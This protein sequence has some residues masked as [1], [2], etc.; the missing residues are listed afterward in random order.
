MNFQIACGSVVGF[1]HTDIPKNNQ[2]FCKVVERDGILVGI[3]CDGCG[4]I[5]T[6]ASEFGAIFGTH[7]ISELIIKHAL[8][9]GFH[10]PALDRP[11]IEDERFW[12]DIR[13]DVLV[14][15]GQLAHDFGGSFGEIIQSY[16]LFTIVGVLITPTW[17]VFFSIG[18]GLLFINGEI[19]QLG[20][21]PENEPPYIAFGLSKSGNTNPLYRFS[22][23]RTLETESLESFLIGCDGAAQLM[24]V[25][26]KELPSGQV[27]GPIS[28]FWQDDTYYLNPD[29][30]RRKL[31]LINQTK[32]KI[33]RDGAGHIVD[34]KV[35]RPLLKD[36]TTLV[37]GRRA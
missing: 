33:L 15:L 24:D 1:D 32:N 2:D 34:V 12:E 21:F 18:D 23:Q 17:S 29:N 31:K 14:K 26:S 16:F 3:V 8:I 7:L 9:R 28:Q 13:Q 36:D 30:L 20:P 27:I 5:G 19:L 22:L 10:L 25:A 37:V 35:R 4:G 6:V 11:D